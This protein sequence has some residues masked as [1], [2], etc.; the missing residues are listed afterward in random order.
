M[1]SQTGR[2]RLEKRIFGN[3]VLPEDRS[4]QVLSRFVF[5]L[6][7]G[8]R[9]E[10][11]VSGIE[12]STRYRFRIHSALRERD[13]GPAPCQMLFPGHA[14]DFNGQLRRKGDTLADG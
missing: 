6:G 13:Q 2:G 1:R 14:L 10:P 12:V 5:A 11:T 8:L 9:H 7:I 3:G 4:D